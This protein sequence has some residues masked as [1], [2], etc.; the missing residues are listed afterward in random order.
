[1]TAHRFRVICVDEI[2]IATFFSW[3]TSYD[4]GLTAWQTD[5]TNTTA[6][7]NSV[8]DPTTADPSE[9]PDTGLL[10]YYEELAYDAQDG[11]SP[12]DDVRNGGDGF[13][14]EIDTFRES[15]IGSG[16]LADTIDPAN[17]TGFLPSYCDNWI[18][19]H[20]ITYAAD[21]GVVGAP[22]AEVVDEVV[23]GT[24]PEVL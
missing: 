5:T 12:S 7:D 11:I 18:Y 13:Y 1:M 17:G 14:D 15:L 20:S 21:S 10:Y 2:G 4:V 8:L 24:P 3:L 9:D 23:A 22:H 19:Q 6:P 16:F